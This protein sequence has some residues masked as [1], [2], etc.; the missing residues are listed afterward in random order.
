MVFMTTNLGKMP[1]QRI[2]NAFT[3]RAAEAKQQH[4]NALEAQAL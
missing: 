1:V 2:D 3:S 4:I